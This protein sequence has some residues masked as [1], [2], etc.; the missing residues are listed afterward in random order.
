MI[1][2]L[3]R[4][5]PLSVKG[6]SLI[7]AAAHTGHAYEHSNRGV[8]NAHANHAA[9][10]KRHAH[11]FTLVDRYEGKTFFDDWNFFSFD[12]PTHGLVQYTTQEEATNAG[13][14]YVRDDGVAVIKVDDTTVLQEGEHR[15]S[16]RIHT[17]KQYN[18]G[19][20]LLDLIKM[21]MGCSFW[22]A[23]WTSA[24]NWP[25]GGEIDILEGVHNQTS[26]Q[27]TLHTNPGCKLDTSNFNPD[28]NV[29][30][31]HNTFVGKVVTDNCDANIDFNTGCGIKDEDN[32]SYGF[33]LATAGGGVFATLWDDNGIKIWFFPRIEIPEDINSETPDPSSWPAP[34]GFWSSSTC[35]TS[36]F[37]KDHSFI[38]NTTLCGD[39]GEATY[40]SAGCP[41]TCAQQVADPANFHNAKWKINHLHVYV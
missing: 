27:S 31:S 29:P 24:S 26:N 13:L 10:I 5:L 15:K 6:L 38:I 16:V 20:F 25:A 37:F 35:P 41:G 39:L 36:R 30:V 7:A 18:G 9:S 23:A 1:G 2:F 22:P 14:A 33:G 32:R 8:Y 21:P 34:K 17:K 40:A 12:D 11:N 3:A 4:N 19:L 28:S